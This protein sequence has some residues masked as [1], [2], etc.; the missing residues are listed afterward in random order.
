MEIIYT[1]CSFDYINSCSIRRTELGLWFVFIGPSYFLPFDTKKQKPKRQNYYTKELWSIT[2]EATFPVFTPDAVFL[3][4]KSLKKKNLITNSSRNFCI[5]INR[6]WFFC[7]FFFLRNDLPSETRY[8]ILSL[9]LQLQLLEYNMK[10]TSF[11]FTKIQD[12]FY[13]ESD[14]KYVLEDVPSPKDIIYNLFH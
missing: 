13:F 11:P 4:T 12:P 5:R 1:H 6:N 9:V 7:Y 14:Q 3:K 2:E 10:D 8:L